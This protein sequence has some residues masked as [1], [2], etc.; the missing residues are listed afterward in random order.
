MIKSLSVLC[1]LC[2]DHAY[3]AETK[4]GRSVADRELESVAT[5]T[6]AEDAE[7]AEVKL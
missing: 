1:A 4:R 2:G 6:T 3:M 7:T 5:S